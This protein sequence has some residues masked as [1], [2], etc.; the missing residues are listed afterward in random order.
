MQQL[1]AAA[2]LDPSDPVVSLARTA[3]ALDQF[4]ADTAILSARDALAKI[5]APRR[6]LLAARGRARRRLLPR[7]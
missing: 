1:D 2:R 5:R 7:R 3:I 6:L 4:E